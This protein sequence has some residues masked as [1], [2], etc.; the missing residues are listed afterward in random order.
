MADSRPQF[1]KLRFPR[2]ARSFRWVRRLISTP[3]V[4]IGQNVVIELG[5]FV[6]LRGVIVRAKSLCRVVVSVGALGSSISVEVDSDLLSPDHTVSDH[7]I[8]SKSLY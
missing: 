3:Y 5:P 6:P 4:R 7:G 1:M 2:W 8:L